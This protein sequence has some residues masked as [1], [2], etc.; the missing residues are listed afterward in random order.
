LRQK[1][2]YLEYFRHIRALRFEDKPNYKYLKS[3]FLQILIN[4]CDP[5]YD[6]KQF[7]WLSLEYIEEYHALMRGERKK[8]KKDDNG[9]GS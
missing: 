8:E 1:P 7:D 3:L 4:D 6:V 9:T 5:P 2:E